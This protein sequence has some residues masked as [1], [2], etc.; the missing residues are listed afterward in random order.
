MNLIGKL[1]FM[2]MQLRIFH[3]Q[4]T[5]F[6]QHEAFGQAYDAL[7]ALIDK[8]VEV[9]QGKKGMVKARDKFV[10]ELRNLSDYDPIA[11]LEECSR[12]LS[13]ELTRALDVDKDTD[14]LN[15]RDEMLATL[16]KTKYLLRL[17]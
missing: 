11:C 12:F 8:F 3:W 5:S 7:D 14:L 17:K 6:A 13:G 16:S 4:T 9:F 2:Q 1:L 10:V 15:L